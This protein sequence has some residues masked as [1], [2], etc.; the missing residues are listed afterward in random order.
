MSHRRNRAKPT[1]TFTE[2][3]LKAAEAARAKADMPKEGQAKQ[4]LW[5]RRESL[6][7]S[8]K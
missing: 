7:L 3:L 2:R 6:K 5:K 8:L 4:T 1:L